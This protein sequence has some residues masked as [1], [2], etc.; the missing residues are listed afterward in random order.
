MDKFAHAQDPAIPVIPP[1]L[2]LDIIDL[3]LDKFKST[4][5][6]RRVFPYDKQRFADAILGFEKEMYK[7]N[8]I[9]YAAYDHFFPWENVL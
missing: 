1:L 5:D 8:N 3:D 9:W 4:F 7:L 6:P 2:L